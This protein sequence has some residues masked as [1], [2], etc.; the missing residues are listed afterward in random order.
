M[1]LIAKCVQHWFQSKMIR[2]HTYTWT[3]QYQ[4]VLPAAAPCA[5]TVEGKKEKLEDQFT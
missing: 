1:K 3:S 5:P 2:E 4:E